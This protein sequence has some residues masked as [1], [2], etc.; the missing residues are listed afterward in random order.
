MCC[1]KVC[2][3]DVPQPRIEQW[4]QRLV[5]S[6]FVRYNRQAFLYMD[7]WI[8]LRLSDIPGALPESNGLG[9]PAVVATELATDKSELTGG[10]DVVEVLERADL[11]NPFFA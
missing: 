7:S 3:I 9:V 5:Q 8:G 4:C 2:R 1:Y 6:S 10:C 11:T